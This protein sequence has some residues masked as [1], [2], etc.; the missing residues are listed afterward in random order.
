M[1]LTDAQM[2]RAAEGLVA[3]G[4]LDAVPPSFAP[5]FEGRNPA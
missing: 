3:S 2:R 5:F 1:K 4:L